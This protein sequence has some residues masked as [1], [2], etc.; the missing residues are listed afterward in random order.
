MRCAVG[1]GA[2]AVRRLGSFS[3]TGLGVEVAHRAPVSLEPSCRALGGVRF[4][5]LKAVRN[6]MRSIGSIGK[7]TK[8]MKM[9]AA[10][11]L[12]GTQARQD[13]S[14]P[15]AASVRQFFDMLPAENLSADLKSVAS[16]H[17]R[18]L[19][20]VVTS[21][22]GLCGSVNTNVSR[23]VRHVLPTSGT[24][25]SADGFENAIMVIG[26]KGRD[27]L[28]RTSAKFFTTTF[29]D[30]FK[31]PVSFPQ[32]VVIAEE[33]LAQ[34]PDQII[35]FYNRFKSAISQLPTQ[36]PLLGLQLLMENASVFDRYE[37]DSDMDS[38]QVLVD[39]FEFEVA[40]QLYGAL[41]ENSTSEQAARMSAM[42]NASTNAA[43]ML[44]KLTLQYNRERQAVITTELVEIV[45]GASALEK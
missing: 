44:G 1:A 31:T 12:R 7:I 33:I 43:E 23:L 24:G 5:S 27:A 10:A 6:R 29:R 17:K 41:L 4:A 38:S 20:V 13:M 34:N 39:L 42:D 21:D 36:Q 32:T 14:R 25:T 22:R 37:F 18:R 28:Q 16:E 35:I 2:N 9:V 40:T 26:D 8:A 30:V 19:L 45:A 15:F 3:G 11:K